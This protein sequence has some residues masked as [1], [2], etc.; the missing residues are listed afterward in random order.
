MNTSTPAP[1]ASIS[2]VT[3]ATSLE[4]VIAVALENTKAPSTDRETPVSYPDGATGLEA[5]MCDHFN[6]E[7]GRCLRHRWTGQHADTTA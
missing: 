2:G 1:T 5:T 3:W 4:E 6:P 7:W